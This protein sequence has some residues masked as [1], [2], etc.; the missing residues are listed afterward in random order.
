MPNSFSPNGDKV[1]DIFSPSTQCE[2]H[3]ISLNVY[4]SWGEILIKDATSWNGTYKNSLCPSGVYAW[5]IT[6][7]DAKNNIHHEC[8]TL[9]LIR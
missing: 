9:H 7:L 1:N 4:N 5:S 3:D 8:G 2:I 6:Y